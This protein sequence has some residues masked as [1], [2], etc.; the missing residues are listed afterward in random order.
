ME[1]KERE[2]S[3]YLSSVKKNLIGVIPVHLLLSGLTRGETLQL[4]F[5]QTDRK[6]QALQ[7][8]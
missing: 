3:L 5:S 6:I 7:V 2:H 8:E 1:G 4:P